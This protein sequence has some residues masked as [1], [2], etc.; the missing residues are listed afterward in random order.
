[1][2]KIRASEIGTY[3]YC[4]RAWLY[5]QQGIAS[6][7]VR[8]LA[9]GD[10]LHQQ[11]GRVVFLSGLVRTLAYGFLLVAILLFVVHLTRLIL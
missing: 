2:R 3:L 7:N 1:M 11:H 8:E 5:Q 10:K 9:Q 6:G 4:E